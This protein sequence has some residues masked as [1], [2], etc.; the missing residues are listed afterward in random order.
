M[1]RILHIYSG[2]EPLV[3]Y[4][5]SK[6]SVSEPQP[7]PSLGDSRR[8]S[9]TEP[10]PQPLTGRFQGGALSLN[11]PSILCVSLCVWRQIYMCMWQSRDSLRWHSSYYIALLFLI[12]SLSLDRYTPT[13]LGWL[14]YRLRVLLL[15]Q[16]SEF[17]HI[18]STRPVLSGFFTW[19]PGVK[20]KSCTSL[21]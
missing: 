15:P 14:T 20:L 4:V 17:I 7:S 8:G 3:L 10:R 12:L 9:T 5:L 1:Q 6:Y 11:Y 13:Q 21:T 19:V 16:C 18:C 2:I